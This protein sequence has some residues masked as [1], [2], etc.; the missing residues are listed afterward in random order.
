MDASYCMDNKY[1]SFH[2]SIQYILLVATGQETRRPK[3]FFFHFTPYIF[4]QDYVDGFQKNL[5][6]WANYSD[7]SRRERSPRNGGEK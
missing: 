2:P 7:L 4:I 1:G 3:R 6:V 5:N